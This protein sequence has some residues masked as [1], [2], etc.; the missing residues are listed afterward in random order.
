RGKINVF[1]VYEVNGDVDY[2][3]GNIDFNGTVVVR[4]SVLPGFRIRSNGDIR[5]IGTVEGAFLEAGGSI[6]VTE[7]V[8]GQNKGK[9]YA[10][11]NVKCSF[12][13]DAMITAGED[14]LV[15]QSIMHSH[16]KA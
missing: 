16:I 8:V 6:E 3:V 11:R 9:L 2:K 10:G 1:P 4:G 14:V 5:I 13:Q 12:V 7:G 15:A